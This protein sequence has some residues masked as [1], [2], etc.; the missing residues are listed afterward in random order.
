MT[1]DTCQHCDLWARSA[2]LH[3]VLRRCRID[4]CPRGRNHRCR[5]SGPF[6]RVEKD[7]TPTS[8]GDRL[9]LLYQSSRMLA[10]QVGTVVKVGR[11]SLRLYGGAI[12][13]PDDYCRLV[14][15]P[16][17]P[18]GVPQ[19]ASVPSDEVKTPPAVQDAADASLPH[20]GEPSRAC[21]QCGGPVSILAGPTTRY[22]PQ[23]AASRMAGRK[24]AP[25]NPRPC[26]L[27]GEP[28]SGPRSFLCLECAR[29]RKAEGGRHGA[30]PPQAAEIAA[31]DTALAELR[32]ENARLQERI[33][34]VLDEAAGTKGDA[35]FG[36]PSPLEERVRLAIRVLQE[37]LGEGI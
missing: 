37:M 2:E 18:P 20:Q 21:L 31:V 17:S 19:D 29:K 13:S 8:F 25:P 28:V 9:Y 22:C 10:E 26:R 33:A 14:S 24:Q 34:R 7:R 36:T 27:C 15:V 32:A 6:R 30:K 35:V 1:T 5:L 16:A 12:V 3:G 23:C 4:G 11:Y